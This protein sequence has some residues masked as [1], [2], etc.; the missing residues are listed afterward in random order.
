MS[1]SIIWIVIAIIIVIICICFYY[2]YQQYRQL[3]MEQKTMQRQ[4]YNHHV[5]L[6]QYISNKKESNI[7]EMM[8]NQTLPPIPIPETETIIPPQS[9]STM[10]AM[11][12]ITTLTGLLPI[13]NTMISTMISSSSPKEE[14][15]ELELTPDI[16]EE[17]KEELEELYNNKRKDEGRIIE[18][19]K[20]KKEE[21][22]NEQ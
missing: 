2:I 19:E 18:E 5:L 10:N 6:Q 9:Q 12:G 15:K 14:E 22:V 7:D 21:K 20:N 13:M 1:N 11:R 17:I 3:S 8:M 16:R 4:I